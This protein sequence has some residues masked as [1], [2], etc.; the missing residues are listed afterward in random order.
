[1]AIHGAPNCLCPLAWL[2]ETVEGLPVVLLSYHA[3]GAARVAQAGEGRMKRRGIMLHI[4]S[5]PTG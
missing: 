2:Q 5:A 3:S 4:D 1:M